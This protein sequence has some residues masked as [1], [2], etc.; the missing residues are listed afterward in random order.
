MQTDWK[1][2]YRALW[3]AELIAITGFATTTPIIPLFLK[4]MGLSS[5]AELNFWTGLTHTGA[6]LAM[7]IFAP[8]WGSLA[9]S[10]GRKLMLLRAM[11]GG[12]A[13]IGLMGLAT[14]PWQVALLRTL[15][16]CVT[17]TVAAATVLTASL[18]P[19]AET[20]YRL[21]LMQ[22]AVYLG[23]SIGPMIGG[24][25]S[26][27]FGSR[28]NFAATSVLLASG[29]LV[30]YKAVREDFSPK[31]RTGSILKNAVP[32]FSVLTRTPMLIS[33][34]AVVFAIQFA[35]S[36][37]APMMPLFVM[38]ITSGA[39]GSISGLIISAGSIAGAVAAGL[40]GKL[41]GKL[42]YARTLMFCLGGAFLFYLPQGFADSPWQLLFLRLGSGICLG[43]TMPSV[44]A[45]IASVCDKG[46]Q[47]ATYGLS[48]SISS[49]GMAL[50]PAVGSTVATAAGYPAVFFVTT[51]VLGGI[52]ILVGISTRRREAGR[53]EAA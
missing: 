27:G 53:K 22:M 47:G 19:P 16:G 41:S 33:L 8:I 46:K 52:G 5:Q 15:Q 30:V 21:G 1:K 43:G 34:F 6:S 35:N 18:V 10:Y 17:G 9:D 48:S 24:A 20:G 31:P 23:N 25:L 13:L 36:V 3:I 26:D 45:L 4:D 42:G 51:G 29:A 49:A 40:I 2:S 14:A 44:N 50:G 37:V 39:V 38:S 7:A 11:I 32:D 28:V 12:A